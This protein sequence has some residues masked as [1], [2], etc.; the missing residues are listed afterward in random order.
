MHTQTHFNINLHTPSCMHTCKSLCTA[1]QL[2]TPC[3]A[4]QAHITQHTDNTPSTGTQERDRYTWMDGTRQMDGYVISTKHSLHA[5]HTQEGHG[6][7]W[8]VGASSLSFF[9]ASFLDAHLPQCGGHIK[10]YKR[11]K[12]RKA[13]G[14][15]HRTVF[16]HMAKQKPALH[17]ILE[18]TRYSW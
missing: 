2:T 11:K 9:D 1:Q 17:S 12:R 6:E 10:R 7:A 5:Q 18:D 14:Q 3:L 13:Q 4:S 15:T 16:P 8:C